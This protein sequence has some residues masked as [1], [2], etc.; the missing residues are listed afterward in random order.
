MP[1]PVSSRGSSPNS[2]G[3]SSAS[4]RTCDVVMTPSV[5]AQEELHGCPH[6]DLPLCRVLWS[7]NQRRWGVSVPWYCL[8]C[9]HNHWSYRIGTYGSYWWLTPT[10]TAVGIDSLR[11]FAGKKTR[12][13]PVV[14]RSAS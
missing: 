4:P 8:L 12:A 9:P 3:F 2:P 14:L 10:L 6:G 13:A 5:A 7:R 1:W 11:I